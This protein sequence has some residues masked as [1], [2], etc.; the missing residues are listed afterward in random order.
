[1]DYATPSIVKTNAGESINNY[2]WSAPTST[3]ASSTAPVGGFAR[4]YDG[5][6]LTFR[7]TGVDAH[8]RPL[9]VVLTRIPSGG[10]LSV[11][12][13]IG[14]KISESRAAQVML[15]EGDKV[16]AGTK[17]I[18]RPDEGAHDPWVEGGEGEYAGETDWAAEGSPYDWFQYRV[19]TDRGETSAND[20]VMSLSVRPALGAARLEWPL[21]VGEV[22]R[23]VGRGTLVIR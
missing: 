13:S 14:E 1:M 23:L 22:A 20:A 15:E 21:K 12:P 11:A 17:L 18:Y 10:S 8:A 7:V 4:S 5:R 6:S 19:E 9:L 2:R 3:W 16:P